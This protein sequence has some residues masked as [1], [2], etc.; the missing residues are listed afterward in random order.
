MTS[1]IY[2]QNISAMNKVQTYLFLD[3]LKRFLKSQGKY[4]DKTLIEN[5][6]AE[7][8]EKHFPKDKYVQKDLFE[9]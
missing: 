9:Q 6:V 7:F 8:E 4:I 1:K 3:E 2:V 5:K